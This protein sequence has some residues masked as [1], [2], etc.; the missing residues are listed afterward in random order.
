MV[1]PDL[2]LHRT[3]CLS[4][5]ALPA[6]VPMSI[7]VVPADIFRKAMRNLH[8]C[9][10]LFAAVYAYAYAQVVKFRVSCGLVPPKSSRRARL[11]PEQA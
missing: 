2:R 5:T 9:S 3:Q 4:L 6:R 7:R 1:P 11:R 8:V 10:A